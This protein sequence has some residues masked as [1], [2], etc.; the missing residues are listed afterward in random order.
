MLAKKTNIFLILI[1]IIFAAGLFLRVG[2]AD[3]GFAGKKYKEYKSQFKNE[4]NKKNYFKIRALKRNDKENFFF[5][6]Y[7]CDSHKFDA[8]SQFEKL[9]LKSRDLCR[10]YYAYKGYKKYVFWR[11]EHRKD[12]DDG[13]DGDDPAPF[14]CGTSAV[15]DE[16]G[17]IYDTVPV[18]DQ[19]WTASN[20][21]V[22]TK[23][24][25]AD[26]NPADNDIVEKWC[27]DNDDSVC[28]T[29]G[30]LYHWD[31]AMKYSD[32]EGARGI[33]PDDW[34]IP[35]DAELF[36]LENYLK[37][38]GES[39]DSDRTEWTCS[40]AGTKLQAGG[41]SGMDFPLTGYRDK[42]GFFDLRSAFTSIWSSSG[43]GEFAWDRGLLIEDGTV[44]RY[45][46]EKTYGSSI[47]CLK[48]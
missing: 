37:D 25:G 8:K 21:N 41:S 34:H 39:C 45:A 28:E 3:A 15:E 23:L 47:R 22:G 5:W 33:C 24:A 35:T 4:E 9:T 6:K 43:S 11:N 7:F 27:Y 14:V 2:P 31:E 32:T 44:G 20:M 26:V 30:G 10:Q 42:S 46:D 29:E 36:A 1:L 17:N 40:A 12:D 38:E 48:D 19:C 13:N 16:D 18:N